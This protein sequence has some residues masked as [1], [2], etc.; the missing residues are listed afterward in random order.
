MSIAWILINNFIE[1]LY[2]PGHWLAMVEDTFV[3]VLQ[4]SIFL[5]KWTRNVSQQ[6]EFIPSKEVR[7]RTPDS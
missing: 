7:Q 2:H 6:H 5:M 4:T 1:Q 3:V